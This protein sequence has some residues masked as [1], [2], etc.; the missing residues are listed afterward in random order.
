[1]LLRPGL[2]EPSD[3][4]RRQ[5]AGVLAE[6]R[7]QRFLE[8]AGGDA[9]EVEDRD[10]HLEAFRPARVGWQ[11]RRREADALGAFA[12]AIAHARAA[13]RHRAD[14]GHDLTLGQMPMAHQSLTAIVGE[15]VGMRAEQGGNLS[16][17]RL[18][19][20]RSC[21]VAQ[22]LGQ[23]IDKSSWLGELENISLG[24][25]VSLLRWRSGGVKHPHDTPPYP[26]MPSPT[27]A[28]SS[29]A[30]VTTFTL[31]LHSS[32]RKA[33]LSKNWWIS[34]LRQPKKGKILTLRWI[35]HRGFRLHR[36][37]LAEPWGV[38]DDR[39]LAW[40]CQPAR[41]DRHDCRDQSWP[42]FKG[43]WQID[44]PGSAARLATAFW[45]LR[46]ARICRWVRRF[47]PGQK[48]PRSAMIRPTIAASQF[49]TRSPRRR[50]RV[51]WVAMNLRRVRPFSIVVI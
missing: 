8:V 49:S 22:H 35:R 38:L 31:T 47:P 14:A 15:F 17:D 29:F 23:R 51:A 48:Q 12:N 33:T 3:G 5:P 6:Q 37:S 41:Q 40:T 30:V 21:A 19:H 24:H 20:Q 25:G 7:D 44:W 28:H 32:C 11:Y 10:K 39:N 4:R 18:R 9:L 42:I 26:L 16:L 50:L 46:A 36:A 13:H 43:Q 27:F 1:M 45:H 34:K 2:L